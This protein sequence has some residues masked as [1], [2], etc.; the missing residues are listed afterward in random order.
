MLARLAIL[1]AVLT[2]AVSLAACGESETDKYV[3]DY[4][5]L[6]DKL[7]AIGSDLGNAVDDVESK[8]DAALAKQFSALAT[9]LESLNDE[10]AAL[11]TPAEL[12]DEAKALNEALDSTTGDVKDIA[13]A[14]EKNDPQAAAS[15]TVQLSTDAQEVNTA[16]NKLAKATGAEVGQQ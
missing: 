1:L 15:A 7:L 11:D 6:N 2:L 10:I 12:K 5:P 8:S 13:K 3:D 14:A 16:Q 9:R 4:K